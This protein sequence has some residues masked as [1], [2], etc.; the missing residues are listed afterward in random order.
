MCGLVGIAG[1]LEYKDE[2]TMKRML[3]L[4]YFRGTDSTGFAAVKVKEDEVLMT[5]IASHPIDLFDMGAFKKALNGNTSKVFLGH[6]RAATVGKVNAVNAHPF[7]VGDILGVHNGT[8]D[9]DSWKRL[10][11]TLGYDTDVDRDWETLWTY[12]R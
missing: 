5:K 7:Q 6:N 12:Y 3:I 4:D 9:K 2:A 1:N 8:L 11:E 10:D